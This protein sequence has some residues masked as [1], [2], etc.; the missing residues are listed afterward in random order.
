MDDADYWDRSF[1]TTT[2]TTSATLASTN[3][4]TTTT[5]TY[6]IKDCQAQEDYFPTSRVWVFR[7]WGVQAGNLGAGSVEAWHRNN[8][9]TDIL[10]FIHRIETMTPFTCSQF[11]T[12]H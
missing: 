7:G 11:V 6:A 12:N 2:I 1:T 5:R 3:T 10:P 9:T 4:P 8:D